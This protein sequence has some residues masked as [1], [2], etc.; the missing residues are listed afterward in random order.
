MELLRGL[1]TASE[2]SRSDSQMALLPLLA[3][4]A[5]VSPPLPSELLLPLL[6]GSATTSAATAS[7]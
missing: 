5:V 6:D 2:P 7:C 3:V 1:N 4:A